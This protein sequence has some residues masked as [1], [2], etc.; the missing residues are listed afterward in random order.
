MPARR[1]SAI[2]KA[3][4]KDALSYGAFVISRGGWKTHKRRHLFLFDNLGL[5]R[6]FSR[7]CSHSHCRLQ[8]CRRL[9]ALQLSTGIAYH[10][11]WIPSERNPAVRP[12]RLWEPSVPLDAR[13][14]LRGRREAWEDGQSEALGEA[15]F[16]A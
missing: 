12:S 11:V 8:L 4:W 3:S 14:P 10:L 9:A 6:G 7:V 16:A 2:T 5:V 13:A 1:A 15:D